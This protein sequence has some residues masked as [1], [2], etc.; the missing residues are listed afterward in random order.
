[1]APD[2]VEALWAPRVCLILL[3]LN[4]LLP[5][6]LEEQFLS[7]LPHIVDSKRSNNALLDS[8]TAFILLWLLWWPL[9]VHNH[10]HIRS[11]ALPQGSF[12][13][14]QSRLPLLKYNLATM[15]DISSAS[16]ST[17][18]GAA[19][20]SGPIRAPRSKKQ[21]CEVDMTGWWK[22]H[23]CGREVNPKAWKDTCPECGHVQCPSCGPP[24]P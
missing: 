10:T 18:Q 19:S 11:F 22:C 13:P 5:K 3:L 24:S 23:M 15:S 16:W 1:M 4:T 17:A 8:L 6:Y 21:R 12:L 2:Q 20:F 7:D 14:T 9:V